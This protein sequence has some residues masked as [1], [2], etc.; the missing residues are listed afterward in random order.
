MALIRRTV[1]EE[2]AIVAV[3]GVDDISDLELD[4]VLADFARRLESILMANNR[5][6]AAVVDPVDVVRK[7][8]TNVVGFA[9]CR[10]VSRTLRFRVLV[11]GMWTVDDAVGEDTVLVASLAVAVAEVL[12]QRVF[13]CGG[14][15][16]RLMWDREV[17]L[18]QPR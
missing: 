17:E 18:V 1:V 13:G 3:K 10:P 15:V 11:D 5:S 2:A 6:T 14:L 12:G 8:G 9:W 7:E 16:R 4:P